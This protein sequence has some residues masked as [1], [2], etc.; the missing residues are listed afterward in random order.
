VQFPSNASEETGHSTLSALGDVIV[1]ELC[2][3]V[4]TYRAQ[5]VPAI[6]ADDSIIR[7]HV[8]NYLASKMAELQR[9]TS[10]NYISILVLSVERAINA[11]L[12]QD[13]DENVVLTY[14]IAE[15]AMAIPGLQHVYRNVLMNMLE[16]CIVGDG[17]PGHTRESGSSPLGID[18]HLRIYLQLNCDASAVPQW[19]TAHIRESYE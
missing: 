6:Y 1:T 18:S 8:R 17:K 5:G 15:T 12:S 10:A 4:D 9:I 3:A 13:L 2:G 19:F 16:R 7:V 14:I 11:K